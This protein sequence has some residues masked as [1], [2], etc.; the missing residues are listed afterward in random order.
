MKLKLMKVQTLT[1]QLLKKIKKK[2]K[3]NNDLN[4]SYTLNKKEKK[5]DESNL[6][7][8]DLDS[9]RFNDKI[10]MKRIKS[11]DSI[12]SIP[13]LNLKYFN[14]LSTKNF[15]ALKENNKFRNL[16]GVND[17]ELDEYLYKRAFILAN[18]FYYHP[19]LQDIM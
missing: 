16:H 5:S 1:I 11:F 4:D 2:N 10:E 17:L 14:S 19:L 12:H 3:E 8:S 15:I 7:F 9:I 18:Q 6:S 13:K